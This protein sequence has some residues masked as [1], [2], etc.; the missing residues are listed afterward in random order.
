MGAR[1]KRAEDL[2]WHLLSRDLFIKK[3]DMFR[4]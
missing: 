4:G 3:L 1:E 2:N